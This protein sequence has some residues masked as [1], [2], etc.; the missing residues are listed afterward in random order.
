VVIELVLGSLTS[1]PVQEK[2][3]LFS[4]EKNWTGNQKC[5]FRDYQAGFPQLLLE[6][7]WAIID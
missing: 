1:I 5:I 4:I 7:P 6:N 2:P 3:G